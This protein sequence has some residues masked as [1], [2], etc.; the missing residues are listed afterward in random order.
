MNFEPSSLSHFQITPVSGIEA[1]TPGPEKDKAESA[2]VT[3]ESEE[4]AEDEG[5][6]ERL[7]VDSDCRELASRVVDIAECG[8]ESEALVGHGAVAGGAG[9]CQEDCPVAVLTQNGEFVAGS[10][11]RIQPAGR[12]AVS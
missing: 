8:G 9:G 1:C 10:I 2:C 4:V 6:A 3:A 12:G 5:F 7:K 11:Q